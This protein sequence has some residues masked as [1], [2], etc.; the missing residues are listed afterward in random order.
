MAILSDHTKAVLR[1]RAESA[2]TTA[3]I[4]R[5]HLGTDSYGARTELPPTDYPTVAFLSPANRTGQDMVAA[6]DS[7]RIFYRA[8]LPHDSLIQDGDTL[9]V[10]GMEYETVQVMARHS[11]DVLTQ[12]LVVKAGS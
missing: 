3:I 10:D 5:K 11:A 2:M 6:A 4:R 1:Q 12:A 7:G 8:Q 9:I